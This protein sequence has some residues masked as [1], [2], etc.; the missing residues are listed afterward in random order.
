MTQVS[1]D[2]RQ[3]HRIFLTGEADRVTVG[4]GSGRAANPVNVVSGVLRQ[5]EVEHVT[6]IGNVQPAGC[7]ISCNQYRQVPVVEVT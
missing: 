4:S 6:H 7:N 2:F 3:G 1:L 5:V